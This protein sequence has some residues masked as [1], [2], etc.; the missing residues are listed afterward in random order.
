MEK[1]VDLLVPRP[2]EYKELSPNSTGYGLLKFLV[3]KCLYVTFVNKDQFL[4]T[5]PLPSYNGAEARS[6]LLAHF[7]A[8]FGLFESLRGVT[9]KRD[10]ACSLGSEKDWSLEIEID[11]NDQEILGKQGYTI[12]MRKPWTIKLTGCT[13]QGLFYGAVTLSQLWKATAWLNV[14][15]AQVGGFRVTDYP[16]IQHR[17]VLYDVTRNRVPKMSY[18]KQLVNLFASL[19]YNELQLYCEHAFAYKDHNTVWKGCSPITHEELTELSA[20]CAHRHIRLVANQNT[21]GHMHRWLKYPEYNDM[22]ECP[23]GHA[24]PFTLDKEPFSLDPTDDRTIK[25][26]T[27]LLDEIRGTLRCRDVVNVN[28]DEAFDLGLGKSKRKCNESGIATVYMEYLQKLVEHCYSK[29]I[30]EMM[31][32]SDFF[33]NRPGSIASIPREKKPKL[34]AN[35]TAADACRYSGLNV[36]VLEWG[37]EDNHPF[38]RH[39]KRFAK[40]GIPFYVCPGTSS[41]TSFSGRTTNAIRNLHMAAAAG[42]RHGAKGYLVTE[43]GDSGHL[44]SPSIAYLPFVVGASASWG[45]A[46]NGPKEAEEEGIGYDTDSSFVSALFSVWGNS[47][48]GRGLLVILVVFPT[49]VVVHLVMFVAAILLLPFGRKGSCCGSYEKYTRQVLDTESATKTFSKPI[50]PMFKGMSVRKS[51]DLAER[52]ISLVNCHVFPGDNMNVLGKILYDLG[53]IHKQFGI[54]IPNG[55]LL[56]WGPMMPESMFNNRLSHFFLNVLLDAPVLQSFLSLFCFLFGRFFPGLLGISVK[57]ICTTKLRLK[58]LLQ[59]IDSFERSA[60]CQDGDEARLVTQELRWV[61]NMLLFS[62]DIWIDRI[63]IGI[64]EPISKI[65]ASSRTKRIEELGELIAQKKKLWLR[66]S[67]VGGMEESMMFLNRIVHILKSTDLLET[68]EKP[69]PLL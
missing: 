4:P 25:L 67:R 16:S 17:G 14:D 41:W 49:L 58:S 21:L 33:Y 15:S 35:D 20:F 48:V 63:F 60:Q 10:Q 43:W 53:E 6:D 66:R 5:Y 39:C 56:F 57:S 3:P 38:E 8:F 62:C 64:H 1:I 11:G 68:S 54:C 31:I 9:V 59:D 22:S 30:S 65:P 46:I 69:H 40:A 2:R 37:Y 45:T 29:K 27:E 47:I 7:D 50:E 42:K 51:K 19:K 61:I 32:W 26:A 12:S 18:L 44:Q 36:T 13:S 55:T 34:L 24:S 23:E 28:L 52:Y